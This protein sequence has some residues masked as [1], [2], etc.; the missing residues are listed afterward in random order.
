MI[1]KIEKSQALGKASAPPSKSMAHRALICGALSK[2]STITNLA[3][4]EDI[5]AT[6]ACLKALGAKVNEKGDGLEIGSLDPFNVIDNAELFCNESGSTLRFFIPLC[7]LSSK[8]I[9]LKGSKRLFERPLSVYEQICK[10]QGIEIQKGEAHITVCGRLKSGKYSVAGDISSQFI[11]GLLFA[12]PLLDGDSSLEVVGNFESAS[13]VDLTIAA[14]K[15]FGIEVERKGNV[16][17]IKGSQSYKSA[18]YRVEG[19]MSNAAFLDGFNLLGGKVAVEDLNQN[20]LQGDRVYKTMYSQLIEGKK[21]FDLS[22]CPDL[23]PVMFALAAAHGGA[24]FTGTAR[25]KIKESD[26]AAAMKEELSKLGI[27]TE[28]CENRVVIKAGELKEPKQALCSHNDHRIVMALS[29]LLSKTGGS[30]EG[31]QAVNK[32]YPDFFEVIKNL[33]IGME[34]YDN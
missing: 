22:D 7:M 1:V 27:Q 31:A 25:L 15:S 10:E 30:I 9:T 18:E 14:L 33:G 6:L 19:D 26:R 16:F 23:A 11:T 8:K 13:Y 29:L 2:K 32:S 4:S 34:K 20:T 3:Q 24:E 28:I 12:L 21:S 5:K 17:Y